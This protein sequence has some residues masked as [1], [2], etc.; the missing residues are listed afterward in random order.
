MTNIDTL[1]KRLT[2]ES[3]Y[4]EPLSRL[5][6]P[7]I[8]VRGRLKVMHEMTKMDVIKFNEK[9]ILRRDKQWLIN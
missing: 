5:I 9:K 7:R 6:P 3:R 8:A 2:D 1:Y 4:P